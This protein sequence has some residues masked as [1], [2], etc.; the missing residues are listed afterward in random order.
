MLLSH[1]SELA[2]AYSVIEKSFADPTV[3]LQ[4]LMK[5]SLNVYTRSRDKH[6]VLLT[7]IEFLSE[8]VRDEV[9]SRQ[10][11]M[12]STVRR[13]FASLR[14]DI[15]EKGGLSHMDA[16]LFFGMVNWTY[17]WYRVGGSVDHEELALR[18]VDIFLS[19][20]ENFQN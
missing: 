12:V 14:P 10:R 7:C 3:R 15:A 16:M 6:V 5:H 11:E 4:E 1:V 19:G 9:L 18:A 2:E 20:Y 8:D 13:V 17:T